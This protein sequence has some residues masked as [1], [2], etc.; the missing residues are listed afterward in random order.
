MDILGSGDV[1]NSGTG[2]VLS[3]LLAILTGPHR[4]ETEVLD[5]VTNRRETVKGIRAGLLD[6]LQSEIAIGMQQGTGSAFGSR[7]LVAAGPMDLS[8]RISGDL[9]RDLIRLSTRIRFGP[10]SDTCRQWAEA[11]RASHPTAGEV[12]EWTATLESWIE[13]INMMLQPPTE[14]EVTDPCP[15]CAGEKVVT[16]D[17]VAPAVVLRYLQS[18]PIES[19]ELVCHWCGPIAKGV[20]AIAATLRIS[21]N[22]S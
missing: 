10:L 13:D 14:R 7:I 8:E 9:T 2:D 20:N 17:S 19:A 6:E 11:F 4:E 16:E 21:S 22:A 12:A 3:P 1:G 15:I 18:R 5:P